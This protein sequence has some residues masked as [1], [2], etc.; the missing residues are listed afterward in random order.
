VFPTSLVLDVTVT[1][2]PAAGQSNQFYFITK[3]NKKEKQKTVGKRFKLGLNL[4]KL[5]WKIRGQ[6]PYH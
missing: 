3:V 1:I 6:S 2:Q 5:V 4:N